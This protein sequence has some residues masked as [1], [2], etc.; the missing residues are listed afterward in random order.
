M[1][2]LA[3]AAFPASLENNLTDFWSYEALHGGDLRAFENLRPAD[4]IIGVCVCLSTFGGLCRKPKTKSRIDLT[5]KLRKGY[6]F[7]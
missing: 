1:Q 7:W 3:L 4:G 6:D 5:C 2:A